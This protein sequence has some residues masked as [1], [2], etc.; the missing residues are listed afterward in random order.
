MD[1]LNKINNCQDEEID[2]IITEALEKM[3]NKSIKKQILGFVSNGLN[4]KFSVHKGFIS[5]DSK[6]K[7][8]NFSMNTY[9]M[10]TT[11][12]F[13]EF[14][15]FIKKNNINSRGSLVKVIE[16][17]IN[18][19]FGIIG[20]EDLRDDYFDKI[21]YQTTTTDDEYFKKLESLEIGDLKGKNIA[22]CTE[23]SAIAQNLLSLFDFEIYYCIGCFNYNEKQ[24][25]HCFN[26][27]R[28][29]DSYMLLDYSVPIPIFFNDR[30]IDY[31]PF[32]GVISIDKIEDILLNSE[33]ISFQ[34]YEYT[35]EKNRITKVLN[36]DKRIYV[37]GKLELEKELS[38]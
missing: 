16:N 37:V 38:I 12:Y 4:Y 8:G 31:A 9:S 25:P 32:Q 28:A 24:E 27:A 13:Y 23:R 15:R 3:E 26:I 5:R 11:D 29:K 1:L 18:N 33:K 7:Y 22:M 20:G 30:I 6:V 14:A 21:A 10:K 17:F 36:K 2:L 35:K 19:Y 34:S